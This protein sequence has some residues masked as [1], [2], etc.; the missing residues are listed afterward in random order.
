[1]LI[2]FAG[3]P[4][5][6]MPEV[7]KNK[8]KPIQDFLDTPDVEKA[9]KSLGKEPLTKEQKA[10]LWAQWAL[11][12]GRGNGMWNYNFGNIAVVN[13]DTEN[14]FILATKEGPKKFKAYSSYQ[15][16]VEDWLKWFT[17]KDDVWDT[18]L[19]HLPLAFAHALKV[20]NYYG[21]ESETTYATALQKL[22]NEKLGITAPVKPV[23]VVK[24]ESSGSSLAIPGALAIG[25]LILYKAMKK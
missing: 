7:A 17:T 19:T 8:T 10:L 4:I 23:P 22:Y 14:Y 24:E 6:N 21:D 18:V 15:E 11:E 13:P 9:L 25:G 20:H 2:Q 1:M 16:G 5:T 12:T 3:K